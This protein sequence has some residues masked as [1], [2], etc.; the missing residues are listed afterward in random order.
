MVHIDPEDD[1]TAAPSRFL[2]D[3]NKIMQQIQP[4]LNECGLED[5]ID[6][7]VLHY[8]EGQIEVELNLTKSI[9]QSTLIQLTQQCTAIEG[10]RTVQAKQCLTT[11]N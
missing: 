4:V 6:N 3:R 11:E 5:A 8:L 7:I 10:I 9:G 2:P 1:E